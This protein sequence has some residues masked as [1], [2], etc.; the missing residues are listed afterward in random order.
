[1]AG[2][3]LAVIENFNLALDNSIM[4]AMAEELGDDAVIPYD[5]IK[6]PSGGLTAF[7]IPGDD[8]DNPDTVKEIVGIIV[9]AHN[10][11]AY[12]QNA[13]DGENNPPDCSSTDGKTG[14][15]FETG[16]M[17]NCKN[18][19][20]NQFGSGKSNKGKACKNMMRLYILQEGSPLPLILTL[21]P[22]S[23]KAYKDY[24][25]RQIVTKGLRSYHVVTR[26]T[27]KKEKNAGGII[28][29]K[30]QFAKVGKV[31]DSMK[32]TLAEYF[33]SM[34]ESVSN[35]EVNAEDY[36]ISDES[37]SD[38]RETGFTDVTNNSAYAEPEF[39]SVRY[40]D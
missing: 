37:V 14:I 32:D 6:I 3:E 27:L 15:V 7:E 9:Y 40:N 23:I 35:I 4:E 5:R 30:A 17:H 25:G 26:I 29:S 18:C 34:K 33:N 8:P 38:M 31:P 39:E 11:N 12:W 2:K 19:P 20:L 24:V 21:P 10:I 13:Y 36:G 16:E 1:M 28:Y 22:T